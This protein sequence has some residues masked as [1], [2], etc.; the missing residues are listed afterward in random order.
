MN[1]QYQDSKFDA[2]MPRYD[3]VGPTIAHNLN[4]NISN[5]I[6]DVKKQKMDIIKL[7]NELKN[8]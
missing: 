3:I 2:Q 5:L 8:S 7:N 4:I 1:S 6:D